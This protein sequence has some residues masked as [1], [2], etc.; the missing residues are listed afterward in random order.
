VA[1]KDLAGSGTLHGQVFTVRGFVGTYEL[2]ITDPVDGSRIPA[3]GIPVGYY[4]SSTGADMDVEFEIATDPGFGTAVVY[5]PSFDAQT[6]GAHGF[7]ISSGLVNQTQYWMR[8]RV[9]EAGTGSWQAWS[10]VV[11]FTPDLDAGKGFAY[12]DQN[13]GAVYTPSGTGFRYVDVN[14]GV[15]IT[16]R[17]DT[18]HY[19]NEEVLTGTPVPHLWFVT[20]P[21]ARAGDGVRIFGFG[22]GDLPATFGGVV[23]VY[24][25][26]ARGW[27]AAQVIT[28]QTYGASATAYGPARLLDVPAEYIDMQ[29]QV[30]EITV[31]EDAIPP[32][33]PIRIRTEG[34]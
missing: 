24:Y 27:V 7:T 29:H 23:E 13:I 26:V 20:P 16:V 4:L 34:P 3:L 22:L 31:P 15:E 12:V 17:P 25:G 33:Y 6:S 19:V 14:V 2:A 9:S 28:W 18:S 8:G 32:G 30:V 1:Y 5:A 10:T 21:S 11:R